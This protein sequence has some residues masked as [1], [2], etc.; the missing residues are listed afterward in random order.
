V[1]IAT[2]VGLLLSYGL[3]KD[4]GVLG[5]AWAQVGA[6]VILLIILWA[7]QSVLKFRP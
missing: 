1:G 5:V 3:Q 4:F 7:W 6:A 2:P